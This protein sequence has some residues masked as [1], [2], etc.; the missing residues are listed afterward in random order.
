MFE[1][2]T[3]KKQTFF[4]SAFLLVGENGLEPLTNGL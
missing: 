4:R 3:I 1:R 2:V